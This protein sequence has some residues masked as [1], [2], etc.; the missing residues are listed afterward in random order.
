MQTS[1]N[2][3]IALFGGAG[4]WASAYAQTALVRRAQWDYGAVEDNEYPDV[5]HISA[6]LKGFG[7]KGIEDDGLIYQQLSGTFGFFGQWGAKLAVICC[8]S[9]HRH[10]DRLQA[11]HPDIDIVR[12]PESCAEEVAALG[13]KRVAVMC[14]E[15]AR[16]DTLH[17]RALEKY[18]IEAIVSDRGQQD[19]VNTIIETVMAGD[20]TGRL[21]G[22]YRALTREFAAA[23]AQA[24]VSGCTE[25]SYLAT[26]TQS[27]LPVVDCLDAALTRTLQKAVM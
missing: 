4:P 3:K 23:G 25:I 16:A 12:L 7:A 27:P 6:A 5:I 17:P 21:F 26:K 9:L 1:F 13:L 20:T 19:R 15:S 10:A 24:I 2:K 14:S 22:D 11:D 18:G 8:N